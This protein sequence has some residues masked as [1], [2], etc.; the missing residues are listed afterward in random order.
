MEVSSMNQEIAVIGAG[1]IRQAIARRVGTGKRIVL[2]DLRLENAEAAGKV[3]ADAG[4]EVT[5][6][7]VDVSSR[8]SVRAGLGHVSGLIH[9]AGVSPSQAPPEVSNYSGDHHR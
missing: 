1:S 7:A 9:A 3:I 2:A 5:T 8:Q 4:F 6:A